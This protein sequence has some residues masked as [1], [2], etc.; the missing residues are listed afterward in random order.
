LRHEVICLTSTGWLLATLQSL[1]CLVVE[2]YQSDCSSELSSLAYT[3]IKHLYIS[4]YYLI[5]ASPASAAAERVLS[6]GGR[7]FSPLRITLSP[8][9]FEM[10]KFL[11]LA[12]W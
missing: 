11:R 2:R 4:P 5:Q 10:M 1:L 3:S 7:V 8:E 9:H 6:L 12:K